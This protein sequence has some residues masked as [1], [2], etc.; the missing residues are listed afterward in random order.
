MGRVDEWQRDEGDDGECTVDDAMGLRRVTGVLRGRSSS[1]SR[2][3][4]VSEVAA[5]SGVRLCA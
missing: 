3:F 4:G 1:V 5:D 2:R